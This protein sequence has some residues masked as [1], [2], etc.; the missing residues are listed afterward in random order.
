MWFTRPEF[1]RYARF[2]SWGSV[3]EILEWDVLREYGIPIVD[4]AVQCNIVNL[5]K[6]YTNRQKIDNDMKAKIKDLCSILIKGSL[7]SGI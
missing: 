7:S 6:S 3:R 2:N 5:R 4:I 1:D